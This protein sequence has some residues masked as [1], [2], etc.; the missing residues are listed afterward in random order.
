MFSDAV[1][2]PIFNRYAD[3]HGGKAPLT[4]EQIND[5]IRFVFYASLRF[6]EGSPVLPRVKLAPSSEEFDAKHAPL[7]AFGDR[8][9]L[10]VE[11][12]RKH[13]LSADP[14][15]SAFAVIPDQD[16]L[17]VVSIQHDYWNPSKPKPHASERC[18]TIKATSTG[19]LQIEIGSTRIGTLRDGV[20]TDSRASVFK[21]LKFTRDIA[22]I[23]SITELSAERRDWILRSLEE[24]V[25]RA[26]LHG[27]GG[28]VLIIADSEKQTAM[29]S[30]D[31]LR[32]VNMEYQGNGQG[33]I[34]QSYLTHVLSPMPNRTDLMPERRR[35]LQLCANL[36]SVD[37]ALIMDS[38]FKPL[39]FAAKLKAPPYKSDLL[40]GGDEANIE[41]VSAHH[42]GTRHSSAISFVAATPK[43]LAFV[44]SADGPTTALLHS[45]G[46]VAVWRHALG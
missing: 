29:R 38:E 22:G 10:T 27:R 41:S 39:G 33:N 20:L 28:T 44:V 17:R 43:S 30:I 8:P 25:S 15:T 34:Q 7:L 12:L 37:G 31:T 3:F 23:F 16:K 13:A 36:T 2:D 4:K 21:N 5:C 19:T 26:A 40:L 24:I 32:T 14:E 18:V 46:R 42:A 11:W 9:P 35:Y 45:K 6:E 1:L